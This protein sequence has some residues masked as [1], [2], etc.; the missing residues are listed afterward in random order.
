MRLLTILPLLL[1]AAPLGAQTK[2]QTVGHTGDGNAVEINPKSV[3]R[4]GTTVDA[5]VRVRFLKPKKQPGGNVTS[6]RTTL[7]FDCAKETFAVKENTYYY[8]EKANKVFQHQVVQTPGYGP[9]MGGSMT[10][11]AY[12]YLCKK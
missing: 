12:D 6:S 9:V 5:V 3:K 1:A 2:W 10:K 7:T 11:V 4:K 8:D